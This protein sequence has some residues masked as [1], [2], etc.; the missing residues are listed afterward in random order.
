VAFLVDEAAGVVEASPDDIEP[1]G[2]GLPGLE[3]VEGSLKMED[4][5][6]LILGRLLSPHEEAELD[7]AL[8][9][10]SPR[11]ASRGPSSP[12]ARPKSAAR[13]K[14]SLP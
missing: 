9:A 11:T 2:A 13:R 8:G 10:A 5:L 6:I 3:L 1:P 12:A 14:R 7:R 4:G